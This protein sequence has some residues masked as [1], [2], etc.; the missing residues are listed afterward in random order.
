MNL[1][2]VLYAIRWLIRDTFRQSLA[3]RVFWLMLGVSGLCILLCLSA[4][5]ER[6]PTLLPV[7]KDEPVER[8]PA[9]DPQAK[10]PKF[11][12]KHGVDVPREKL[13]LAFGAIVIT[14]PDFVNNSVYYLQLLLAGG[15]ADAGG[16]LLALLW[17]AG[18]LPTFLEPN[19]AAVLLAKP[20]PRWSLLIGKYLGVLAFVLFQAVIFVGGTWAALGLRTGYWTFTYLLTVPLLLIHFAIFYSFSTLLA[21][22]TRNTVTCVFGSV[23]FWLLCWGMNF[24]RN[25]ALASPELGGA[26]ASFGGAIELG[27]WILPKPADMLYLLLEALQAESLLAGQMEYRAVVAKGAF[28]PE[29]SVL[30]SLAFAAVML[31]A[32][33]YEFVT[34]DY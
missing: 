33:A 28:H 10:D 20:V 7:I 8:L 24:G 29:L 25:Y 12:R 26:A 15:V 32:S 30:S 5:V 34:T 18:F 11:T 17:T 27:Y 21:V 2:H 19:H 16:I 3:S 1:G 14:P 6:D 22:W 23:L 13:R 9:S 4:S 31:A